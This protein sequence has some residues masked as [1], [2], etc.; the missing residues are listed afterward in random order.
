MIYAII[1]LMKKWS[2]FVALIQ[3]ESYKKVLMKQAWMLSSIKSERN[4]SILWEVSQI[5]FE[6]AISSQKATSNL[7]KV[8]LDK[9]QFL[10][11]SHCCLLG[12]S[13]SF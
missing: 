2:K 12:P 7:T 8:F 9:K 11:K 3:A 5:H 1:F 6:K 13:R 4:L 10:Q